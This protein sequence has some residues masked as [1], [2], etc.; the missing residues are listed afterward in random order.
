MI[1]DFL[2][3][4][5]KMKEIIVYGIFGVLATIVSFGSFALLR[6]FFKDVNES[7]LNVI[8]II[9]AMIFAYVTNRKFVFKSKEKNILKEA[10]LF[11]MSRIFSM[12]FEIIAFFILNELIKMNGLIAKAVVTIFVIIINYFM[13]KLIVFHKK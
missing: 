5:E 6:Y 11:F 7:I 3:N 10:S 1:L 2:K 13:S 4:K 9:I 12:I 8:S